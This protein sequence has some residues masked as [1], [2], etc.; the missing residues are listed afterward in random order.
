M[1]IHLAGLAQLTA[2]LAEVQQAE[3]EDE[4]TETISGIGALFQRPDLLEVISRSPQ[5][6]PHMGEP[7]FMEAVQAIRKTPSSVGRYLQDP[8]IQTLLQV[9][10]RL[11]L[12]SCF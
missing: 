3:R 6:A 5:L 9:L 10:V 11:L 4:G 12:T 2:G 7:D 8:R 1:I